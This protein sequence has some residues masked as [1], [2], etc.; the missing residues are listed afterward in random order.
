MVQSTVTSKW[1]TTLPQPVRK[2]LGLRP[3]DRVRYFVLD[4]EVRIVAVRPLQ[5]L[6]GSLRYDG[7]PVTLEDMERAIAEQASGQ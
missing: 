5:R 7:P 2:A 1:Q 4:D 3:G 6:F